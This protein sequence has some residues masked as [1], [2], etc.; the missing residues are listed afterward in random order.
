MNGS[1]A[2]RPA[3]LAA[4]LFLAGTLSLGGASAAPPAVTPPEVQPGPGPFSIHD[5]DRD[6]VLSRD[7]YQRFLAGVEHRRKTAEQPRSYLPPLR[8][9]EI[10]NNGDGYLNEDEMTSALNQRLQRHKRSR[11][12]TGRW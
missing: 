7:E 1:R 3:P 4:V 11:N 5:L 2:S 8:F 10:D 6:G 9:E 12:R